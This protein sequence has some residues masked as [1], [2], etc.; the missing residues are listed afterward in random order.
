MPLHCSISTDPD[1]VLVHGVGQ[2]T[3][4]DVEQYLAATISEGVKGYAKLILLGSSTLA[5]SPADLDAI[6]DSLI[7][8]GRGERPGA[9]A[10]VAGTALNLDMA[11]LLKQRVGTRPFSIFV[12]ARQ[13]MRWLDTFDPRVVNRMLPDGWAI[14]RPREGATTA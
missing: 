11:V 4:S 13:A 10:I 6:A 8:Y 1:M 3:R 5:L 7:E 12:D 2:I 9:V 14:V